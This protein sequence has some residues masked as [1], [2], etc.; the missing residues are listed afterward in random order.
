LI[1]Y[2]SPRSPYAQSAARNC[3]LLLSR[4]DRRLVTFEICDIS[5]EPER[6]EADGICFTPVLVKRQPPPRAFVVGDLSNT[7]A[8]IDLLASCGLDLQR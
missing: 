3:E 2:L 7:T 5:L 6:A 8:I 4:F 1:L